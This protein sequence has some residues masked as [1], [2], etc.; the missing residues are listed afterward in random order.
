MSTPRVVRVTDPRGLRV[1]VVGDVVPDHLAAAYEKEVGQ[2]RP[3]VERSA[4]TPEMQTASQGADAYADL[5]R[6][7]LLKLAKERGIVARG[8]NEELIE[9]LQRADG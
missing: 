9:A 5:K 8:S 1:R 4:P 3:E 7:E 6:P 2:R